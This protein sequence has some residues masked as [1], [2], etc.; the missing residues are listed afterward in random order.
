M[1]AFAGFDGLLGLRSLLGLPRLSTEH[2][3][4]AT[5]Q[6]KILLTYLNYFFPKQ[7][8]ALARPVGVLTWFLYRITFAEQDFPSPLTCLDL[9][10]LA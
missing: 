5:V 1:L 3:A 2:G 8:S 7:G 9:P 4:K 6:F 10:R